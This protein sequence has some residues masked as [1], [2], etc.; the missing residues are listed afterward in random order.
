MLLLL[1]QIR[2]LSVDSS[3]TSPKTLHS[4]EFATSPPTRNGFSGGRPT[5]YT[6]THI[7]KTRHTLFNN[8]STLAVLSALG[9]E[10]PALLYHIFVCVCVCACMCACMCA[11]I[12]A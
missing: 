4:T 11:Y 8:K 2:T 10:R 5:Q 9:R 1:L 12:C 3:T 6:V 7:A